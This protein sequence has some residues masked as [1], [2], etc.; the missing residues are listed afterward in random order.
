[1]ATN[2]G[3]GRCLYFGYGATW[4]FILRAE[5]LS[6]ASGQATPEKRPVSGVQGVSGSSVGCGFDSFRTV[7]LAQGTG[8]SPLVKATGS[9]SEDESPAPPLLPGLPTSE[10]LLRRTLRPTE[11]AQEWR[12]PRL[13]LGCGLLLD[14]L[15]STTAKEA[16]C[17]CCFCDNR[18][19]EGLSS[20]GGAPSSFTIPKP[21]GKPIA[22]EWR[23][24]FDWAAPKPDIELDSRLA[25]GV[26]GAEG[27]LSWLAPLRHLD[28]VSVLSG[29]AGGFAGG[30]LAAAALQAAL[31]AKLPDSALLTA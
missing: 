4:V 17:C 24:P 13:G 23:R 7:G 12:L 26:S 14:P 2:R 6:C 9:T 15:L 10:L 21:R 1:M 16:C 11:A 31:P 25:E 3:L 5:G 8:F 18:R 29:A 28:S 22:Q 19:T 27:A 20:G 30:S